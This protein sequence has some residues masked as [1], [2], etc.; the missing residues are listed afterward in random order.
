MTRYSAIT[1]ITGFVSIS[2]L[3]IS[4]ARATATFYADGGASNF[5]LLKLVQVSSDDFSHFAEIDPRLLAASTKTKVSNSP[6]VESAALS[7]LLH[8]ASPVETTAVSLAE[9]NNEEQSSGP[10]FQPKDQS[11][12]EPDVDLSLYAELVDETVTITVADLGSGSDPGGISGS[13]EL[14]TLVLSSSA[15]A[16]EILASDQDAPV[17]VET[18]DMDGA[19]IDNDDQRYGDRELHDALTEPHIPLKVYRPRHVAN[20]TGP[21]Q[22]PF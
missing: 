16:L 14:P 17:V 5:I 12:S 19:S 18:A 22:S 21:R 3:P 7:R 8:G 2:L 1:F 11:A 15:E 6:E 4:E 9:S 20:S 13:L 10:G